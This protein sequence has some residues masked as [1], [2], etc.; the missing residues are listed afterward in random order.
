MIDKMDKVA[1]DDSYT[2]A[3]LPASRCLAPIP[4]VRLENFPTRLAKCSLESIKSEAH[5]LKTL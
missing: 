4:M 3:Q 5:G 2:I 1:V